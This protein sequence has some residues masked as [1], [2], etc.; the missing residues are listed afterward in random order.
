MLQE[1]YPRVIGIISHN[2]LLIHV[3]RKKVKL[4]FSFFLSRYLGEFL[5]QCPTTWQWNH[6][7]LTS[8]G[9][10]VISDFLNV[11]LFTFKAKLFSLNGLACQPLLLLATIFTLLFKDILFLFEEEVFLVRFIEDMLLPSLLIN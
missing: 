3:F 10:D 1:K 6:F 2:S 4:P 8:F 5:F 9:L 11:G 7:P